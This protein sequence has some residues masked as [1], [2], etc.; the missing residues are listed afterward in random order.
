[1]VGGQS[2]AK[3]LRF[4]GEED[5]MVIGTFAVTEEREFICLWRV[6][7]GVETPTYDSY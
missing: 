3:A 2:G 1:L 4:G 5:D 7:G 6:Y